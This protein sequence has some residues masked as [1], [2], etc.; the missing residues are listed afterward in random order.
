[1]HFFI[2]VILPI[3]LYRLFTY[4]ISE[5]EFQYIKQGMRVAVP[6]GKR[7]VYAALV[8]KKHESPPKAYQAKEIDSILDQSPIVTECQLMH[9]Q[10]IASYYMCTLG[11]VFRNAVPAAFLLESQTLV[12]LNTNTAVSPNS[13]TDNE[14]Q[15]YEALQSQSVLSITQVMDILDKKRVLPIVHKMVNS[16]LL[17]L[18]EK[19]NEQYKPKLVR[20]VRLHKQYNTEKALQNLLKTLSGAPKQRQ[21]LM[22]LFMLQ[23]KSEKTITVNELLQQSK[24]T[25]SVFKTLVDKKVLIAYQLQED[26]LSYQGK[27]I[28][29][30]PLSEAQEKALKSILKAFQQTDVCLLHGVTSSGK[31]EI[32]V[33]LIERCLASGK[34]VL[35]LL[36]EIAL[37]TQLVVRLNKHFGN[38]AAIYHSKYSINERVEVWNNVLYQK[39]KARLVIGV[40]SAVNLPFSDLGLVI[41]DESHETSYKQ[42]DPAPRYQARDTAIYLAKLHS[43]KV[44]LGSATPSIESYYNTNNGKYG[45]VSLTERYTK[46]LMPDIELVNLAE[47]Y[48]KKRMRGHF[49][50]RLVEEINMALNAKKQVILFQNR[51]GYAPV[52]ECTSCGHC[53][54]C[55]NCDV[56]LN[57]HQFKNQ[58]RCHYCGYAMAMYQSCTVCTST[59]LNTKGLGTQQIE[60]EVKLLFEQAKIGRMDFDS[61]RGKYGY[62]KIISAFSNQEL[63][64]LVGTQMLTKGLDFRHVHLVG[65]LNADS[66]INHPD[67]RAQERAYQLLQQVAGRSGRHTEQGK[68][69]IQTYNPNHQIFR[70]VVDNN[71]LG[72]YQSQLKERDKYGYPPYFRII[73][74]SL[75]QKDYNIIN[76]AADWLANGLK[77]TFH[78][79]V[80]GPAFPPV[81]RIRNQYI[82]QLLIKIPKNQSLLKTKETVESLKK[83]FEAIPQYR[84]IK[85]TVDVDCY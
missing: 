21:L 42:F 47:K 83:R 71:Y 46:V 61:T 49:S 8:Y 10:W 43:A 62:Q 18:Q 6:F 3:P 85:L 20:Y 75:K 45:L 1:M 7:K 56:S 39:E 37:T 76:Q 2:D 60:A 74:I 40:R 55:P 58:L 14:F 31:T 32:Y 5:A 48:K 77:A 38:N 41:I 72:M 30:S 69:I 15:I 19:I 26:R 35:Y 33:K 67:F 25:A 59:Q 9:W 70:Q 66:L 24:V 11:E 17:Q 79:N 44:L 63:D 53:P 68:V 73:R 57:Y 34:Q 16:G 51:R 29:S 81:P 82:K 50:D 65:V 84:K 27:T 36:P 22:T 54:Q 52:V 64:I 12:R 28:K 13:L 4:Q 78:K 80:L 23:A